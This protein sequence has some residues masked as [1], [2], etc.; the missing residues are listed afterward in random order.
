MPPERLEDS[1]GDVFVPDG[2]RQFQAGSDPR[3]P[4]APL[5][6]PTHLPPPFS[7][8]NYVVQDAPYPRFP[9]PYHCPPY[10]LQSRD[11][12]QRQTS[13]PMNSAARGFNLSP[14]HYNPDSQSWRPPNSA[15]Q[16][17][18]QLMAPASQLTA[19][20]DKRQPAIW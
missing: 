6:F 4:F 8:P 3:P 1:T 2:I 11:F 20:R 17:A 7:Y 13:N 16:C 19:P 14:Q 12:I 18:Q 10:D 15:S 9:I 5:S